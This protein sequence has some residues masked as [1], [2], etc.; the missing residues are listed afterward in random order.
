[1]VSHHLPSETVP[2]QPVRQLAHPERRLTLLF[3]TTAIL[4]AFVGTTLGAF[5]LAH[6]SGVQTDLG[7]GFFPAHPYLQIYGFVAEFVVGVSYSLLPR[8]KIRGVPSPAFGYATYALMTCGNILFGLSS[9]IFA[10][11]LGTLSMASVAAIL[12]LAASIV[13]ACQVLMLASRP[14]G[15]FPETNPLMVLSSASLVLISL[16]VLLTQEGWLK[17]ETFSP[18]M[19][20]LALVGFAGS[21]IYTVEIRSVSFRQSNYRKPLA[22]IAP[23]SQGFAIAL[24]FLSLFFSLWY[25]P[26]ISAVLFLAAAMCVILSIR[27]F[28][29]AHPLMYR[30]AMKKM[31]FTIVKYNEVGIAS[32]SAWLLFGCLL[33]IIIFLSGNSESFF[34]KDSFIHSIALGF[35]GS[36]I[37][38]FAPML[39]PG[40]LG[41]KAPITGL[42]FGPIILLNAGILLRVLGDAS[43][44]IS[45]SGL[46][47][48][49]A[50]S[51][52]AMLGAMIWLLLVLPRIGKQ[53]VSRAPTAV[54]HPT[55]LQF[56]DVRDASITVT[57]RRSAKQFTVSVW[58]V[59]KDK[60]SFFLVPKGGSN[61]KWYQSVIANPKIRLEIDKHLFSGTAHDILERSEVHSVIGLFKDK[62]GDRVY[63][64]FYGD[65]VDRAVLVVVGEP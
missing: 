43:A 48:W 65:Q 59:Q 50:L 49:E 19:I 30:P 26:I 37:T 38:V 16:T 15:G 27:I 62:Y 17:S 5:T 32:G 20:F 60:N 51:G 18:Q 35:I 10:G 28:E 1:M 41:R 7:L 13:F 11:E 64:N 9:S 57:G 23:W 58:F 24:A 61:S 45:S 54:S 53:A 55:G 42:S 34:E 3:I 21:M 4:L 6:L 12:M 14:V 40:L 2:T 25:L 31:H 36:S 56:K 8:F 29:F 33:G 39:L 22:R 63:R 46:P 52:P 44:L 47:I